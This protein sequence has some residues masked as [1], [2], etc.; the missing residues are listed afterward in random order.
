MELKQHNYKVCFV[1]CDMR[2]DYIIVGKDW[3]AHFWHMCF[4]EVENG[5]SL[6]IGMPRQQCL[7]CSSGLINPITGPKMV[8]SWKADTLFPFLD[9]FYSNLEASLRTKFYSSERQIYRPFSTVA[10]Q[11]DWQAKWHEPNYQPFVRKV[12]SER[13]FGGQVKDPLGGLTDQAVR[14]YRY[15]DD[16]Q[17][18]GHI[19]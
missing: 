15:E 14:P 4:L 19:Y 5:C 7:P 8:K 3:L 13:E 1:N 6:S 18:L 9:R 10:E 12:C 11:N 17:C 2:Y 16:A